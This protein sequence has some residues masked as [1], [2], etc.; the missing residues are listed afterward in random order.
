MSNHSHDDMDLYLTA[1]VTGLIGS[2]HC[3]GMCGPIALALPDAGI[4]ITGKVFGRLVYNSGRIITY[5]LLGYLLGWFGFGLK[6][7]GIQQAVSIAAGAIMIMMV[8]FAS[9]WIERKIGNPFNLLPKKWIA[10][11]FSK[12]SYT[13]VGLIGLING[14]LP[15]G[16]VYIG[17]IGSVTAQSASGGAL[18]M[19]F[20]GFG[21]LPMMFGVSMAG[22]FI[23]LNL[24]KRMNRVVPYLAILMGVLFILRGLDLGIPYLSPKFNSH[25][26]NVEACCEPVHPS[27][28]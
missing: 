26:S 8:L 1:F 7:A 27:R 3:I 14:L 21:T 20:F 25:Q 19:V 15:C 22:Q 24:R 2:F 10:K 5:G 17:L 23:N 28:K 9:D 6:L 18:Y 4:G 13:S 11:L 16:F 12:E